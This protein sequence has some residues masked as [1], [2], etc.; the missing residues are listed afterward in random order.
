MDISEK[1]IYYLNS[2]LRQLQQ[3]SQEIQEYSLGAEALMDNIDWLDCYIERLERE[4]DS[5]DR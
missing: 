2:C 5:R 1:D 3:F 4:Y